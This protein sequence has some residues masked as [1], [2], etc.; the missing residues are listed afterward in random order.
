MKAN[1]YAPPVA[2][3]ADLGT[4]ED[5]FVRSKLVTIISMNA[6]LFGLLVLVASVGTAITQN[7]QGGRMAGFIIFV[8][9]SLLIVAAAIGMFRQRLWAANLWLAVSGLM[10]AVPLVGIPFTSSAN[11]VVAGLLVVQF[12][13]SMVGVWVIARR[14]AAIAKLRPIAQIY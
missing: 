13:G 3:V 12:I 2:A 5:V 10:V 8:C 4:E 6:A 14:R 7:M 9:F 11:Y 1:L